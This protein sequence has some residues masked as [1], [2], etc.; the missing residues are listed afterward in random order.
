VEVK[1]VESK[2][3]YTVFELLIVLIVIG[4]ISI[5]ALAKMSY[6][7]E[8]INNESEKVEVEKNSIIKASEA[9][10]NSVTSKFQE[11]VT[12]IFAKEVA[13]AGFILAGDNYG[14]IK[15]KVTKLENEYKIEI[16]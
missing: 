8:E 4:A 1:V 9:Y 6:S 3:G 16:V 13:D 5:F 2:S 15:I 14:S 7:F 10:V 12:Y 11:E